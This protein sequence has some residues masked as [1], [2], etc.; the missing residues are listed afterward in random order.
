M[1]VTDN[2]GIAPDDPLAAVERMAIGNHWEFSRAVQDEITLAVA[3]ER[4]NYQASFSWMEDIK[5]LHIA[6]AFEM[7]VP[8]SRLAEVQQLIGSINEQLWIGHFD[9]WDQNGLVMFRH[10]LLLT[11]GVSTS[12]R[13]CEAV[14]GAALDSC[15]RYYPALQFVVWA[16]KSAR[17]ALHAA[18]FETA[19]E[20]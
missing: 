14:L 9:L 3:G 18:M 4:T 19:G 5:I 6:C 16:G 8:S 20:A 1:S 2:S 7:K 10:A 17:E 13:Q 12:A 15:E 11:G